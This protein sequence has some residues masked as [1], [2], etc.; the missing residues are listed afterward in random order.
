MFWERVRLLPPLQS[1]TLYLLKGSAALCCAPPRARHPPPQQAGPAVPWLSAH[2]AA[3]RPAP[4]RPARW[5]T[6]AVEHR[7]GTQPVS[8]QPHCE[9]KLRPARSVGIFFSCDEIVKWSENVTEV[10][11]IAK[12]SSQVSLFAIVSKY[13][14]T[15]IVVDFWHESCHACL[16]CLWISGSMALWQWHQWDNYLYSDCRECENVTEWPCSCW[17]CLPAVQWPAVSRVPTA[18]APEAH[19]TSSS[20]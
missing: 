12:L 19:I 20:P 9:E 15:L 10:F 18:T 4:P 16:W 14:H 6:A 17:R 7:S 2:V 5:V 13:I 11:K 3:P 1:P 8:T